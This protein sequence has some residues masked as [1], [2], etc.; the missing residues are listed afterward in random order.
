M[1]NEKRKEYYL[2]NRERILKY[3]REY[4]KTQ[5]YK[6]WEKEYNKRPEVKAMRKKYNNR[7]E[8]KAKRR[9]YYKKIQKLKD[10][11]REETWKFYF[12]K[13]KEEILGL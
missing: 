13:L 8:V 7:P 10:E 11:C 6:D 9:E 12:E 4:K 3:Q 2:K 1:A 5:R